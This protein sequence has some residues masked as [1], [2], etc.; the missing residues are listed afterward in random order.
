LKAVGLASPGGGIVSLVGQL[1]M[2]APTVYQ[3]MARELAGVYAADSRA[4]ARL[5]NPTPEKL[6]ALRTPDS[7]AVGNY[8][9]GEFG[10]DFLSSTVTNMLPELGISAATNL[11]PGALRAL[12]G[13]GLSSSLAVTLT[14][15][16]GM[17]TVLYAL[18]D[19][20]WVHNKTTTAALAHRIV[21]KPSVTADDR[22]RLRDMLQHLP[23]LHA[24]AAAG[25]AEYIDEWRRLEPFASD[26]AIR[27]GL[28]RQGVPSHLVEAALC[29][30]RP[31]E[32]GAE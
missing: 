8:L 4:I 7:E 17:M 6:K 22:V 2:Q 16:I 1:A 12:M 23:R 3:P 10:Y 15:R 24:Q 14:W 13:T 18:N 28:S 9:A 20:K 25:I 19:W 30:R 11:L 29:G 32:S 27:A 26:E 21:G 31:R 5:D